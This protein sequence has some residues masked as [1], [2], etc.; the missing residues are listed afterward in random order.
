[1]AIIRGEF[2]KLLDRVASAE[3]ALLHSRAEAMGPPPGL[4]KKTTREKASVKLVAKFQIPDRQPTHTMQGSSTDAH[5]DTRSLPR[6]EQWQPVDRSDSLE[7]AQALVIG[8]ASRIEARLEDMA[9]AGSCEHSGSGS[10]AAPGRKFALQ[11]LEASK[12][13]FLFNSGQDDGGADL[14]PRAR[15]EEILRAKQKVESTMTTLRA[16][17]P[18][19]GVEQ[20]LVEDIQRAIAQA[21]ADVKRARYKCADTVRV[22]FRL[23]E[24]ADKWPRPHTKISHRAME[25]IKELQIHARDVCTWVHFDLYPGGGKRYEAELR[26]SFGGVISDKEFSQLQLSFSKG[27]GDRNWNPAMWSKSLL[28]VLE[29]RRLRDRPQRFQKLTR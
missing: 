20:T 29:R 26:R 25:H 3:A 16:E 2:K 13:D 27:P 28:R 19:E 4:F 17:L 6:H 8:A 5:R 21:E 24:E 12:K 1:M 22:A 23:R 18:E 11:V 10:A 7:Q 9:E 15:R 14:G